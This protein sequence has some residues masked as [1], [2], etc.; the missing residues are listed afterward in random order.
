MKSSYLKVGSK[1]VE[2]R[3]TADRFGSFRLRIDNLLCSFIQW[4][5]LADDMEYCPLVVVFVLLK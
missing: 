2:L 1:T 4:G 5:E 3:V